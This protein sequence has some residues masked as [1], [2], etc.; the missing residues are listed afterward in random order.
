MYSDRIN[1]VLLTSIDSSNSKVAN[2]Q[3]LQID[4][5]NIYNLVS[6]R[7]VF[8]LIKVSGIS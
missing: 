2:R 6:I 7:R 4:K 5:P 8:T 1:M 3:M